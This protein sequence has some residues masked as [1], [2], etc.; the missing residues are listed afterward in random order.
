M[1]KK[2]ASNWLN[3]LLVAALALTIAGPA[4]AALPGAAPPS[5]RAVPQ[6]G[7]G[8][9]GGDFLVSTNTF[10]QDYPAV[11]YNPTADEY[12]AV[13]MADIDLFGQRYSAQG[14]PL[15]EVFTLCS[16]A[17]DKYDPAVAYSPTGQ[18]YL[19][20]WVQNPDSVIH[21]Q[22]VSA[23]G[24][25]L[26]N[27]FTPEDESDPAVSFAIG[28][29]GLAIQRRPAIAHN[30]AADEYMVVWQDARSSTD[31]DLYGRRIDADGFFLTDNLALVTTAE[32]QSD[33]ALAY[34]QA[35]DN[36]LLVWDDL[37]GGY[38][39][40]YYV[41]LDAAGSPAGPEEPVGSSPSGMEPALAYNAELNQY[42]IVWY[43]S[44][45]TYAGYDVAGQI[46]N[47]DGSPAGPHLTICEDPE[48]QWRPRVAYNATLHQYLVVWADWR[49]MAG[50]GAD[51]YGQRVGSDGTLAEQGDFLI[52]G[53]ADEESQPAVAYSSGSFQFLVLWQAWTGHSYEVRGQ[54]LAWPGLPVGTTISLDASTGRQEAPAVAYNSRYHEYMVVWADERDGNDTIN[55]YA[56]RY[57]RD[58]APLGENVRLYMEE[59]IPY[60]QPTVTYNSFANNYLVA[61]DKG[62]SKWCLVSTQGT[63]GMCGVA[64]GG[65]PAVGSNP[66][67]NS[68]LL[69]FSDYLFGIEGMGIGAD[70]TIAAPLFGISNAMQRDEHPTVAYN[71]TAN[72]YLVVWENHTGVDDWDIHARRVAADFTLV[73]A[74]DITLTAGLGNQISA[75]VAY[76]PV[77]DEYLVAWT[78]YR[79]S[80]VTG[81]DIYVQRLGADGS[82]VG[83]NLVVT[84]APDD[85]RSPALVYISALNRYRIVWEDGRNPANG[86]DLYG[87]WLAADGTV[88]MPF[89]RPVFRYPGDQSSPALAYSPGYD[90]ALTVWQDA[91]NGTGADIYAR[92]GA[93]DTTPPVARFNYAPS[94]GYTGGGFILNAQPST[95]DA[96]PAGM[97]QVRW[98]LDGDG[99]WDT[100]LS[101]QKIITGTLPA[102]GVYT[103]TL[104]V[105]DMAALTDTISHQITVLAPPLIDQAGYPTATL[106]VSPTYGPA[107]T[108]FHVDGSASS[109]GT[110][111]ARWDWE[112]DGHF[113]TPFTTTLTAVHAYTV[114]GDYTIRLEVRDL[115]SGLSDAGFRNVT[116]VPGAV[117]EL[118]V[119]PP[120]VTL[121]TR[122][123]T[124]FTAIAADGYGN[125]MYHPTVTWSMSDTVAGTIA[126]SG[127]FTAGHT[128]GEYPDAI[129]TESD[130]VT[131]N[132]SVVVLE[133]VYRVYLPLLCRAVQ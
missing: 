56:Q 27:P 95:D 106:A 25:L 91:R 73:D 22:L 75:T 112:D 63:P 38:Y 115:G 89:D 132:A 108:V 37:R 109:G 6:V 62:T 59:G 87:Q 49:N 125:L 86:L 84:E 16:A 40:I 130:G 128:P 66:T 9:R 11:A 18:R 90:N 103:M 69:V 42:L 19:V 101:L 77:T 47:A 26:D 81:A 104:E 60:E 17:G 46:V 129:L 116:V 102:P 121:Y 68:Y 44:G 76:N 33:P 80:G 114:S 7:R 41:L 61:W 54:R 119:R 97:L 35:A 94:Y 43:K 88:L 52:A 51:I 92:F 107:G 118:K 10:D 105:W 1:Y 2:S 12:L 111:A 13:W 28:D 74:E 131:V 98:D 79:N 110:L 14:I 82:R 58:G 127:V 39:D 120:E 78:D 70:G 3:V 99:S 34:N 53:T 123:A 113:D 5:T 83:N 122:E 64:Y 124:Y 15:G 8:T 67:G 36:Y 126:A 21:G 50:T 57:D 93:L 100:P 117:V 23:G 96:T 32:G 45:Y 20:V 48:I 133:R 24:T 65:Q 4:A 29:P 31:N 71:P 72:N 85:Q 30:T 55:V